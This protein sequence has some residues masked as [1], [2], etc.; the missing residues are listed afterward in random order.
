[1]DETARFGLTFGPKP[2]THQQCCYGGMLSNNSCGIH[3]Q[4]AGKAVDNTEA[5]EVLLYDGTR[6]SVGWMLDHEFLAAAARPGSEGRVYAA[7]SALR[8]RYAP[9]IKARYPRIPRRVSGYN[10]D[11]LLPDA[12]GRLNV[13][14]ALVGSEGTCVTMLEMTV[15]LVPDPPA[16]G[17]VV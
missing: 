15:R 12:A 16:R 4:M 8:D 17:L 13:A 9:L 5:M 10:L 1:T 2:A 11:A 14:R 6:M 7:L 3:A